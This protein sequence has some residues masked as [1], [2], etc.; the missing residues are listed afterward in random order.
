MLFLGCICLVSYYLHAACTLMHDHCPVMSIWDLL[1]TYRTTS[2]TL[3]IQLVQ[4]NSGGGR[5]TSSPDTSHAGDS[6]SKKPAP[7][8]RR[9]HHHRRGWSRHT[10]HTQSQI[11]SSTGGKHHAITT[12]R[13]DGDK[14]P[15]CEA[16]EVCCCSRSGMS[17][18]Q[19]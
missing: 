4:I 3:S 8:H 16:K 9:H 18:V 13:P 10:T 5:W 14:A 17:T 15:H 7:A 2:P 1:S 19:P 6:E 12:E 11:I